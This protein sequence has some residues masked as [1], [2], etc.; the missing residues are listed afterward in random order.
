[1]QEGWVGEIIIATNPSMEGDAAAM[2]I[3]QK[4]E[5][6]GVR[7]TRLAR[8]LPDGGDL[9]YADPTPDAGA[10]RVAGEGG[11]N[12]GTIY[13]HSRVSNPGQA[14]RELKGWDSLC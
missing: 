2:Y 13:N 8:G 14:Q 7:V 9:E 4:L 5:G 11:L 3:Q 10:E 6:S 12:D 1:M